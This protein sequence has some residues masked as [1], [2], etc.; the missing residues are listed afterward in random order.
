QRHAPRVSRWGILGAHRWGNLPAHRGLYCGDDI[1]HYEHFLI[2]PAGQIDRQLLVEQRGGIE[3]IIASLSIKEMSQQALIRKLCALSPHHPARKA[4]FEFDRLVRSIYT[5]RYLLDP[6]LQRDVH[7]S[8]NR[9]EAYHQLRSMLAQVSGKKHL[10][11]RTDLD[12]AISNECGRLLANVVIAF[13]S[14]LLSALFERY[15][16]ECNQKALARLK[17]ISPVAWQHIHFL[18]H[19]TFRGNANPIDLGVLLAGLEVL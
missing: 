9:I 13:N 8:Q 15:Q 4:V 12:V 2:K 5:L 17:R 19:Y 6:Q 1:G 11:G 7:R 10:I 3:Q 14:M 18:G 16:R